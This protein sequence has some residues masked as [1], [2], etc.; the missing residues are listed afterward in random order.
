M[1]TR[2]PSK[3]VLLR[4]LQSWRDELATNR[5]GMACLAPRSIKLIEQDI[6]QR[7]PGTLASR[8]DRA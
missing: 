8:R 7:W 4:R 5:N 6:E 1:S 3:R 2:T